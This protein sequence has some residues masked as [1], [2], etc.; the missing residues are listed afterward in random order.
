MGGYGAVKIGIKRP[1]LYTFA[2][3]FS[4]A[5]DPTERSDDMPGFDWEN[6]RPSVL[7]A[8]GATDCK[9]RVDNDLFKLIE[10]LPANEV[11]AL[12]YFYF[13]CG[14]ED[15]FLQTNQRLADA[16]TDRGIAHEFQIIAGGHDWD[17]WG[18]RVSKLLSLADE[19][20]APVEAGR[21]G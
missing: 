13:D 3:S 7:K 6:L 9:G 10:G 20:L 2:A 4:G 12:P 1:D 11:S 15:S 5:F 19:R 14:N 21:E 8:F 18:G 17:Y 16:M